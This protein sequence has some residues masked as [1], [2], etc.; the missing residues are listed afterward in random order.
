M[1]SVTGPTMSPNSSAMAMTSLFFLSED[2]SADTAVLFL[3]DDGSAD[4]SATATIKATTTTLTIPM[5]RIRTLPLLGFLRKRIDDQL[6]PRRNGLLAVPLLVLAVPDRKRHRLHAAWPEHRIIVRVS[7]FHRPLEDHSPLPLLP[8]GVPLNGPLPALARQ[9]AEA[10]AQEIFDRRGP[11]RNDLEAP[12]F[13]FSAFRLPLR[14][15]GF[16]PFDVS[17]PVGLPMPD[18]E[19]VVQLPHTEKRRRVAQWER[20]RR[21]V[22]EGAGRQPIVFRRILPLQQEH[23][24][25]PDMEGPDRQAFDGGIRKGRPCD[26]LSA[27]RE[28]HRGRFVPLRC[29]GIEGELAGHVMGADTQALRADDLHAQTV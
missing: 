7:R 10:P 26:D 1:S 8:E 9:R 23:Q 25:L 21:P 22:P 27:E 17:L 4:A 24:F 11:T 20:H 19:V 15:A 3:S 14:F 16:P 6:E 29:F 18:V 13:A 2:L 12:Y 5:T 28:E